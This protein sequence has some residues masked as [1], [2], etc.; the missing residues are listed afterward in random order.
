MS[1]SK[2][3]FPQDLSLEARFQ[4]AKEIFDRRIVKSQAAAA[5][6]IPINRST[7]NYHYYGRNFKENKNNN[8]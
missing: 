8:P 4:M 2:N 3:L 5:A 6:M 1:R 7:F